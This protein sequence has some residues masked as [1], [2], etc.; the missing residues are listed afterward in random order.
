MA[1]S[2]K[3]IVFLVEV[4]VVVGKVAHGHKALALVVVDFDIQAPFG[5]SGD[6]AVVHFAEVVGHVLYL[7]V[8]Y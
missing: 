6:D 7:F 1:A 4:V 8:F 2:H 3:A 5:D